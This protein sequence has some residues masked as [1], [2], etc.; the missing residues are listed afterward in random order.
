MPLVIN[1]LGGGHTDTD[2]DTHTHTE[3][4]TKAISRNQ[5]HAA[6]GRASGL[7]RES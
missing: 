2:T 5:V 7:K 3:M 4:R 1:A 6:E